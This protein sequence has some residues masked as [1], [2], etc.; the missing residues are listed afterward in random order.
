MGGFFH[1][2]HPSQGD[3]SSWVT[4]RTIVCKR[5]GSSETHFTAKQLHRKT[6]TRKVFSMEAVSPNVTKLG[7]PIFCN[8]LILSRQLFRLESGA[9]V[10]A[11]ERKEGF[12]LAP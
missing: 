4:K 10:N 1:V 6:E 8:S 9:K 3:T 7:N 12:L 2:R 11:L 5:V